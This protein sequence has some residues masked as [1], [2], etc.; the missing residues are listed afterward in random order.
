MICNVVIIYST[1]K[2]KYEILG[3]IK[4]ISLVS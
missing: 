2:A 1:F 3:L 4:H